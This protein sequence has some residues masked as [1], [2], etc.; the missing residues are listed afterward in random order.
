MLQRALDNPR[1][2]IEPR[3]QDGQGNAK[4]LV[5]YNVMHKK[6]VGDLP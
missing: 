5:G 1:A 6:I 3:T 4:C 2:R